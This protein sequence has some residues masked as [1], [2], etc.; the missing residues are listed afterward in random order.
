MSRH[1]SVAP[2]LASA[3]DRR[4]DGAVS[5]RLGVRRGGNL[6]IFTDGSV[7]RRLWRSRGRMDADRRLG[8]FENAGAHRNFLPAGRDRGARSEAVMSGMRTVVVDKIASVTQA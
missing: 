5:T 7:Q 3:R 6:A 8:V 2:V 4:G 1:R